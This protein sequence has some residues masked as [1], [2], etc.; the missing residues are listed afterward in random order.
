M[1][2]ADIEVARAP[3]LDGPVSPIGM[4]REEQRTRAEGVRVI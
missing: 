1:T 4:L 3:I 2:K